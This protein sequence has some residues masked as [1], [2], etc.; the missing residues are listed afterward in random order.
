MSD[1]IPFRRCSRWLAATACHGVCTS[2]R[3]SASPTL[4]TRR[5]N[6]RATWRVGR[7]PPRRAGSRA[8]PALRARRL[9]VRRRR[10][11][12]LSSLA[13]LADRSPAVP[14]RARTDVRLAHQ[15]G[16]LRRARARRPNRTAGGGSGLS[17]RV[18]GLLRGA[19]RGE[20]RSSTP[21][22]RPRRTGQVAAVVAAYDFSRFRVIGDIGGGRGHLVR[23]VLDA[24]PDAKGM[25]FDLPHVV[26]E[27]AAARL[28]ATEA[29]SRDFLEDELPSCDA[30]L[31]MEIVHDWADEEADRHPP[32]RS[33]GP[34][35]R[36]PSCC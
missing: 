6:C 27:A 30:Y 31:V 15:L 32:R 14:A 25:L 36:M 28:T 21:R 11:P 22:W 24:A 4:W 23:A 8:P 5:P 29:T 19:P 33:A 13:T 2:P 20:L 17:G 10:V 7:R 12:A 1:P 26:E 3:T 9:R 16:V 34:L 35:R 18:L